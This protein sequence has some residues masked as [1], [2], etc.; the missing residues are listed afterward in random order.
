MVDLIPE[1]KLNLIIYYLH[2][3]L[4]ICK[5]GYN[6]NMPTPLFYNFF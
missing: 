4:E 6:P 3:V 5:N 2:N 1:A